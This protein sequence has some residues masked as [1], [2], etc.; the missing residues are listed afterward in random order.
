MRALLGANLGR[1]TRMKERERGRWL[2]VDVDQAEAAQ[3]FLDCVLEIVEVERLARL[4]PAC[5][6]AGDE[7]S[8]VSAFN[9]CRVVYGCPAND[10]T[11]LEQPGTGKTARKV[12]FERIGQAR[13]QRGAHHLVVGRDGVKQGDSM[14][15]LCIYPMYDYAHPISDALEGITHS[16]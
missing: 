14:A 2:V 9:R 3:E 4:E 12:A 7:P 13:K 11:D 8:S 15:E 10:G 1:S 6:L 5:E 16:I